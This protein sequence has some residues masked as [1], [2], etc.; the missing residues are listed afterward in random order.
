MAITEFRPQ[1]QNVAQ[2]P[3]LGEQS[4]TF[5]AGAQQR[6][7]ISQG[8]SGRFTNLQQYVQANEA[9]NPNA[10]LLQREDKET[11]STLAKSSSIEARIAQDE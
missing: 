9:N 2:A 7:N 3:T 11:I 8:G 5:G 1:N 6:K 4:G 10:Q